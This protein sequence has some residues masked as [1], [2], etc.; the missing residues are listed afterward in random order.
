M[1]KRKQYLPSWGRWDSGQFELSK[2]V[3]ILGHGTFSFEDLNHNN[4]LVI[5]VSGESF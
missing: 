1:R 3:V 2:L 5:L 4:T